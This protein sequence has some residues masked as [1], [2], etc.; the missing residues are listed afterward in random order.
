MKKR[1]NRIWYRN[2][3][4]G[5]AVMTIPCMFLAISFRKGKYGIPRYRISKFYDAFELSH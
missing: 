4:R 5:A 2:F 1:Y 3:V